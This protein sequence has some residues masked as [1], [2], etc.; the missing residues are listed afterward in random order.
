MLRPCGWCINSTSRARREGGGSGACHCNLLICY[1]S[2]QPPP[3]PPPPSLL[4]LSSAQ[5]RIKE[6]H[7]KGSDGDWVGLQTWGDGKLS[8]PFPD[9]SDGRLH[10]KDGVCE[11]DLKIRVEVG[12]APLDEVVLLRLQTSAACCSYTR[13]DRTTGG[14]EG[15]GEGDWV[16]EW[17]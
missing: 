4:R 11:G 8:L 5:Q 10:A 15:T 12:A 2:A 7:R 3:P 13:R 17:P 1:D 6:Q 16:L 9:G 14:G